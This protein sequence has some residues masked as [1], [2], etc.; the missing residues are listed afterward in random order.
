MSPFSLRLVL[1]VQL[2]L[3]STIGVSQISGAENAIDHGTDTH[4][5][6]EG[7]DKHSGWSYSDQTGWATEYPECVGKKLRQSPI[8]II[9]ADVTFN[10]RMQLQ[11]VDYDQDVEFEYTNTHH[12]VSLTPLPAFATPSIRVNWVKDGEPDEYDLQEIHFHWGH[13]G[14]KGSEHEIN[15]QRA[16]AEV[17]VLGLNLIEL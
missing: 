11:F 1:L 3:V 14:E 17:G 5:P 13:A 15:D 9:T 12:S 16:A 4:S 6:S 7:G 10:P 2:S 8:D